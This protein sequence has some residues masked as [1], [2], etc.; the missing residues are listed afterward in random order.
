MKRNVLIEFV[1]ERLA[2]VGVPKHC[3]GIAKVPS[4]VRV[5]VVVRG[6]VKQV[7]LRTGMTRGEVASTMERLEREWLERE[8]HGQVDIEDRELVAAK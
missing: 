6:K 2:K 4:C 3:I 8:V 5:E 7:D 1:E